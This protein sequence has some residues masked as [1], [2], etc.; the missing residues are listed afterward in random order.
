MIAFTFFRSRIDSLVAETGKR[1]EQVLMP[2]SRRKGK[3]HEVLRGATCY[4]KH[5]RELGSIK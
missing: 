2:L 3:R 4:G 5:L 1:V